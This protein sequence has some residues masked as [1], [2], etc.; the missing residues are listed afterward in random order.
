VT[1]IRDLCNLTGS[2][3][4]AFHAEIQRIEAEKV[5]RLASDIERKE[6]EAKL[7]NRDIKTKKN[8]CLGNR[9]EVGRRPL[10]LPCLKHKHKNL[11]IESKQGAN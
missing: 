8:T 9:R 1:Q 4:Q 5:N 11:R 7:Q 6:I 10:L 2:T 3:L